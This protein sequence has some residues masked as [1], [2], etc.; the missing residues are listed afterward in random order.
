MSGDTASLE[1]VSENQVVIDVAIGQH[2]PR[3]ARPIQGHQDG[4]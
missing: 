4:A 1:L 2:L 3:F